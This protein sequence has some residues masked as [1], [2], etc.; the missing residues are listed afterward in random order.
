MIACLPLVHGW[1]WFAATGGLKQG[2]ENKPGGFIVLMII[3]GSVNGLGSSGVGFFMFLPR[4]SI[5]DW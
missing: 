1:V 3:P 2:V 4:E 5:G